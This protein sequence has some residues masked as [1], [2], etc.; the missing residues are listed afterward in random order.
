LADGVG[1]GKRHKAIAMMY[2]VKDE[3]GFSM[4]IA[5]KKLCHQ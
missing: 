3:P 5:P 1:V 2:F 4:V